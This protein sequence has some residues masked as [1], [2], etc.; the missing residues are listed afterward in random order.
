VT[1][2]VKTAL[3][4]GCIALLLFAGIIAQHWFLNR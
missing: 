2:N 3:G 1:K 4:P